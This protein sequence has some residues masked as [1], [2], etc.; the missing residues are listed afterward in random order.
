MLVIRH[1]LDVRRNKKFTAES[2][3][4]RPTVRMAESVVVKTVKRILGS[5]KRVRARSSDDAQGQSNA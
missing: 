3:R 1:L 4:G 5:G 2:G